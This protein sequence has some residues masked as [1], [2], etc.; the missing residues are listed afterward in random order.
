MQV[1][2]LDRENEKGRTESSA[3]PFTWSAAGS[4]ASETSIAY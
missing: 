1:P 2:K 4:A 3:R